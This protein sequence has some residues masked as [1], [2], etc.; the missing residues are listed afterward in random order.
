MSVLVDV[1]RYGNRDPD[2]GERLPITPEHLEAAF[3]VEDGHLSV[4]EMLNDEC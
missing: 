4:R 2:A 3:R 1:V